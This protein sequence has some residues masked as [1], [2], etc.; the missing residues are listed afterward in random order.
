MESI[1]YIFS[2]LFTIW[3][4]TF[5]FRIL[6]DSL[7]LIDIRNSVLIDVKQSL[8]SKKKKLALNKQNQEFYSKYG[9]LMAGCSH[10]LR[11]FAK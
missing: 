11:Q 7:H 6:L 9:F 4:Y 3:F 8:T 5:Y 10:A 1:T 2:R